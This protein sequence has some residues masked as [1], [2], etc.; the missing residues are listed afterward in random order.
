MEYKVVEEG[1]T[2]YVKFRKN[3]LC[4]WRYVRSKKNNTMIMT[5]DS[6]RKAQAYINFNSVK[7]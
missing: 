5:W 6:K 4:R 1:F 7:K 2:F 3:F